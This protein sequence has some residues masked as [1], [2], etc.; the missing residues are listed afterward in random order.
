[1]G[2]MQEAAAKY[3]PQ[4]D[5]GKIIMEN[6]AGAL[7]A[8]AV[9][10]A[11]TVPV[12]AHFQEILPSQDIVGDEGERSVRLDLAF[13]H[14]MEGGPVMNMAPPVQF[15]VLVSGQK[16]DLKPLLRSRSL[17]GKAAYEASYQLK[18]P[19]DYVF[20]VE[21]AA[22]W[23]PAEEKMIVHYAKVVVDFGSAGGWDA[24]VGFPVEIEPLV[25]PYGLWTGNVFRGIVRK[26][27]KPVA[28]ADVE[29]EWVN[30]GSITPPADPFITQVVKT[31]GNGVFAYAMPRAG[32][33]GFAA[34][35]EGD[36]P[37]KSPTGK[38]V[39]V[40]NGALMWVRAVDMN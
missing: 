18:M 26:G 16:T 9:T 14:P 31:D 7:R 33:W 15:G 28:F 36:E 34:L 6:I 22:Y 17:G 10:V 5:R 19:G 13:T 39:P 37:M 20:F 12:Q 32:W 27:G 24:L 25:R 1:M 8:V 23:E 3:D 2:S 11:A 21:P 29:V 40:E 30:D 35:L 4:G 38:D